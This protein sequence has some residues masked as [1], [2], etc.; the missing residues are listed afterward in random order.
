[1]SLFFRLAAVDSALNVGELIDHIS[2]RYPALTE[3]HDTPSQELIACC[4]KRRICKRRLGIK[5]I[6]KSPEDWGAIPDLLLKRRH[7]TDAKAQVQPVTAID[8]VH[9]PLLV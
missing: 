2:Y 8:L 6:L 1:M 9:Q 7:A 3:A 5:H 4:I